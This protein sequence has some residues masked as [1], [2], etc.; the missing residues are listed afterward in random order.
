MLLLEVAQYWDTCIPSM[1]TC[2]HQSH[3]HGPVNPVDSDSIWETCLRTPPGATPSRGSENKQ[4]RSPVHSWNQGCPC[5]YS[6]SC[7]S[8]GL[9][10]WTRPAHS[11][12][13]F[14]GPPGFT[15]SIRKWLGSCL[16]GIP[17]P[18]L[19]LGGTQI[20]TAATMICSIEEGTGTE[21]YQYH[22]PQ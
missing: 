2:R 20:S 6:T 5:N 1:S 18:P 4:R 9:G 15:P 22:L 21:S 11:T 19:G 10:G 13:G 3:S 16:T 7:M 8:S 17:G 12:T 14:W